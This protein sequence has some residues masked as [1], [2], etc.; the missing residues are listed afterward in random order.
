MV[1]FDQAFIPVFFYVWKGDMVHAKSAVFSLS[2][3]W[4]TLRHQTQRVLPEDLDWQEGLR[5]TDR[6]LSDAIMSI[7]DNRQEYALAEL[8]HIRYEL[9]EIRRHKGIPYYL[10]DLYEFHG[11]TEEVYD[12][13]SDDMLCLLEWKEFETLV[14]KLN[15]QWQAIQKK[16]IDTD[17]FEI[18]SIQQGRVELMQ[19]MITIQM[20]KVMDA[21][22]CDTHF[23]VAR[24][25]K[26]VEISFMKMLCD[27]GRFPDTEITGIDM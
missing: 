8:D 9:A 11:N 13:A 23:E 4:Q 17:L 26:T 24:R 10:D 16:P 3:K 19:R 21:L 5:R 18:K 12:V 25:V 7:D 14:I 6:W 2:T 22:Y 1:H 27:F 20:E 15:Q